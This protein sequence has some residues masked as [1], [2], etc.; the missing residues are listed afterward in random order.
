MDNRLAYLP[1]LPHPPSCASTRPDAPT[2]A[3]AGLADCSAP[4]APPGLPDTAGPTA[5][6]AV[7]LP[8]GQSTTPP[9]GPRRGPG[10][11]APV[12]RQ[13]ACPP[14]A[15]NRAC[16]KRPP[17][18][19]PCRRPRPGSAAALLARQTNVGMGIKPPRSLRGRPCPG[20]LRQDS[21]PCHYVLC[22]PSRVWHHNHVPLLHARFD[23]R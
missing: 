20:C 4:R 15:T 9:L 10:E 23:C 7:H 6:R 21:P 17:N 12:S 3:R 5:L 13:A 22:C 19:L 8:T 2:R 18:T 16:P 11:S 14:T 1:R